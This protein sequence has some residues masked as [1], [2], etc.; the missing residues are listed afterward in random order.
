MLLDRVYMDII[1]KLQQVF[2]ELN[3]TNTHLLDEIYTTDMK[4][5]DPA[6]IVE[7]LD[8]FKK[9][10]KNLYQ[11][12]TSCTFNFIK[13]ERFSG[14]AVLEWNMLISHPRLNKGIIFTVSGVSVVRYDDK[15]YSHRDYFDLGGMLYERLPLIG[16]IIK[17]IKTN[18]GK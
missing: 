8:D 17:F 13:I 9:Y 5:E 2:V 18:L 4:F 1:D 16:C 10:I 11:N 3:S 14:G 15:I 6:H 12:V 7:G